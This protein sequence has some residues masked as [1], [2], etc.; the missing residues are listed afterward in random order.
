MISGKTTFEYDG[1]GNLTAKQTANL[2]AENPN[3]KIR[4]TYTYNRLDSIDYPNH[5]ENNVR[6]RYGAPGADFNRAGR[7]LAIEDGGG[8]LE[9]KYGRQGELTKLSRTLVIP[10]QGVANYV[11]QWHADGLYLRSAEPPDEHP[12]GAKRQHC[13][14]EQCLYLRCGAKH[15]RHC[16]QQYHAGSY[17]WQYVA[18]VP[19]R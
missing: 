15:H 19:V 4:Y 11:T 12:Q 9:F 10:N 2:R 16:K 14:D 7:L 5:P 17:R 6:Y 18:S 1:G 13:A 3:K 8:R